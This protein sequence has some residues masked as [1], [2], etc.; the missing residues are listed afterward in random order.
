MQVQ[1]EVYQNHFLRAVSASQLV[2]SPTLIWSQLVQ[3]EISYYLNGFVITT[4]EIIRGGKTGVQRDLRYGAMDRLCYVTN[5]AIS[6][7][8]HQEREEPIRVV[9][10]GP[11]CSFGECETLNGREWDATLVVQS[12]Q[13]SDVFSI[14]GK[15]S[16]T[17]NYIEISLMR[18]C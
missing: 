13:H 16:N 15:V 5:G 7:M 17:Q 9:T 18:P 2:R 6:V 4:D 3:I 11:G 12:I 14:A 10:L 8:R 1:F